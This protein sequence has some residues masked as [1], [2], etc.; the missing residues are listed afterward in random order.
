MSR[1][2]LRL[3]HLA[4]ALTIGQT[5]SWDTDTCTILESETVLKGDRPTISQLP[6]KLST[7]AIGEST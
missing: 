4:L 1:G 7:L 6:L 3:A 2:A 5:Q